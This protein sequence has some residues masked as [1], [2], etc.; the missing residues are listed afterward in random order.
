MKILLPLA[1]AIAVAGCAAR[2]QVQV[3]AGAAS[4]AASPAA[5]SSSSSGLNV[6]TGG[7]VLV[8]LIGLGIIAAAA[9]DDASR[10]GGDHSALAGP[11]RDAP[12]LLSGRRVNEQDCGRP[13]EDASANLK[14]R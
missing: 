9:P 14:C 12:P 10:P 3:N 13:I 6:S 8:T 11:S 2:S 1:A 7:S 4:S 5:I